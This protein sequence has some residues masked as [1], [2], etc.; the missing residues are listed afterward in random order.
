MLR[1]KHMVGAPQILGQSML[2]AVK[3]CHERDVLNIVVL[4]A[5][6]LAHSSEQLGMA[7]WLFGGR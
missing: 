2:V 4:V 1:I 3:F 6:H 5:T 7:E